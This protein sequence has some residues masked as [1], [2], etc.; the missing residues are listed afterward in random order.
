MLKRIYNEQRLKTYLETNDLS[1]EARFRKMAV[2]IE[3]GNSIM[4][5]DLAHMTQCL[6]EM[7][8]T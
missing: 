4:R 2:D 5:T 1:K 8:D 3:T 6:L 7:D